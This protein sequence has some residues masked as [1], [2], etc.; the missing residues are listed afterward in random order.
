MNHEIPPQHLFKY[1]ALGA[2]KKFTRPIVQENELY[3]ASADQFNDPFDSLPAISAE[4]TDAQRDSFINRIL[5]FDAAKELSGQLLENFISA[6][7]NSSETE[8][9]AYY[10]NSAR[11]V[12]TRLRISS[13]SESDSNI[14]MWSH[15]AANHTGIC[16]RFKTHDEPTFF[17]RVFRVIYSADRPVIRPIE[18]DLEDQAFGALLTKA[19]F[20]EYEKEWRLISTS[21]N[22]FLKFP[23]RHLDGIILGA[24]ISIEDE[25]IVQD[26]T[27]NRTAP[28]SIFRAVPNA[29]AYTLSIV[30]TEWR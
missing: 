18:R 9:A 12:T 3:L 5:K 22:R 14:L 13:F 29:R 27:R 17:V 15:Y 6:L 24:R 4:A 1:R 30:P 20:W 25:N 19:A 26:W 21:G 23:E 2:S 10:E 8:L 11:D 16:L 7:K 28:I